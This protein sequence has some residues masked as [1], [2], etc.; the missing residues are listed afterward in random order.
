MDKSIFAIWLGYFCISG[1]LQ[2]F[3]NGYKSVILPS[4]LDY[5]NMERT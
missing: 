2:C 5:T 4:Y 3:G 1:S